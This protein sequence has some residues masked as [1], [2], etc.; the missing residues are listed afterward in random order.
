MFGLLDR[1][2]RIGESVRVCCCRLWNIAIAAERGV[3]LLQCCIM[4]VWGVRVDIDVQLRLLHSRLCLLHWLR[5]VLRCFFFNVV[6]VVHLHGI[7]TGPVRGLLLPTTQMAVQRA[8]SVGDTVGLICIS[9][10]FA[11]LLLLE[12]L[13]GRR[14]R[15]DVR[16]E[17][18]ILYTCYRIC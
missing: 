14:L 4:R 2:G 5:V 11:S 1:V 9:D 16:E 17:F 15:H 12:L 3:E 7:M 6:Y 8:L 10:V 18:E 13:V